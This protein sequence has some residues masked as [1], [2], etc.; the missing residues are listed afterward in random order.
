M[1][2]T[3]TRLV[4]AAACALAALGGIVTTTAL[5]GTAQGAPRPANG[6]SFAAS[7]FT[8]KLAGYCPNTLAVQTSWLPE[9]DFGP[10][11][12]L[13]G[14]GGTMKQY[15]YEG[16]LGSTGIKLEI[17]SGG[18]GD[19]YLEP[20]ATLYS[21]NPVA[22]VTPQLAVAGT[23]DTIELSKQF[24]AT[25]VVNLQDV[26]P[27]VLI[28][29]P[30]KFADLSTIAELEAA[31]AAGAMFYVS[32]M[33]TPYV[34]FLISR[35]VPAASFIGGY[36][37]DL[38][39]FVTG[40]GLIINQGYSDAE[41]YLLQHDT[42]AWGDKPIKEVFLNQLGFKDYPSALQVRSS[43]LKALSGCLSRFVPMVQQADVDYYDH[44]GIVNPIL[45]KLNTPTYGA[46][47]W[48]TPVAESNWAVASMRADDV[49]G[50]SDNGKGPAGATGMTRLETLVKIMLP[51][52]ATESPGTFDPSL[53]ATAIATN[54]FIDPAIRYP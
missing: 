13:I 39:K 27:Q 49:V 4:R 11:Y 12:E 51:I 47:Y 10:L 32:S 21:G 36:A 40:G 46:S 6:P 30:S 54:T 34:E 33:Q 45:A 38:E 44:P 16:K 48:T 43:K 23:S 7:H 1:T 18:P 19:A 29:D 50:N 22:R 25:V 26:N 2:H 28:Y 24:P 37:G 35:G 5:A 20:D 8:T 17:L 41:P 42:P 9:A 14:A 31:A 53:K 52:D 3:R 15:S